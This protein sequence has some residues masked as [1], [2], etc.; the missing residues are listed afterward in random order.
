MFGEINAIR[1]LATKYSKPQLANLVQTGQLEPQKAVLAGMMIDRIAKSAMEPPQ[2]TVAQD[3]LGQAPTAGQMPPDQMQEGQPPQMPPQMAAG[4]GL[5]GMMPHSDGVTALHSGLN[6]MAG[7][8]IVA[9]ADGGDVPRFA[10]RGYVDPNLFKSVIAAESRGDPNA[11]SPK[12]ARGLAQLMPGT[13]RDPGYGVQG[14]R[15][16]SPEE[17]KRVG[18]DYLNALLK[19]YGN[20]DYALAAYNWGPGNTDK[21]IARGA[22]PEEL[23]AETRAYIPKVKAGMAQM[24]AKAPMPGGEQL[25]GIAD[26]IPS[27]QAAEPER[28]PAGPATLRAQVEKSSKAKTQEESD[29]E[30]IMGGVEKFGAA[31]KDVLSLPGRLAGKAVDTAITRPL[32]AFGVDVPYL[33]KEFYGGKEEFSI[34]PYMDAITKKENAAALPPIAAP[35]AKPA[36]GKP[37][38]TTV[39]PLA[40]K[41]EAAAA[42]EKAPMGPER[43]SFMD[44]VMGNLSPTEL[45]KPAQKTI[46]TVN[47]EQQ[48]ADKLY[49]VDTAKMF[50]DL[51]QDFRK[52]SGN[53]KDRSEKA[54]GMA[55]MM[56]GAGLMG[57]KKGRVGEALSRSGQQALGTYMGAMDKINDNEDKLQQRMQDLTMAENQF[58]RGRSDKALA[59]VQANKRDI[60]AIEIENVKLKN[61]AMIEGAKM[62]VDYFKNA[63]PPAYQYLQ[64]IVESEHARG[65]KSYTITDALH[66]EKTGGTKGEV[67]DKDLQKTYEDRLEKMINSAERKEF[68]RKYPTWR[69]F[70]A[71]EGRSGSKPS[72]SST[73]T[74][75][76]NNPL[77]AN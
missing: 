56:F 30:A 57:A 24:E 23:P 65:N 16:N 39:N 31:A 68:K 27:A 37:Q 44:R 58:N 19:K 29:R 18:N 34:S 15:D 8:G 75:D 43:P 7:G 36:A 4:G 5:M 67:T 33:P 77:L 76:R 9:F 2:T 60:Q 47:K 59:E 22:K 3:V 14:V 69:E 13:A 40:A 21:W 38:D 72:S 66:D 25:A 1:A 17:N 49:G 51:R 10:E 28:S 41:T 52:S 26:L 45:E 50:D 70:A 54:A 42:E 64:R 32:R 62:T 53:L 74:V 46:Q 61:Q 48:E 11:V 20:L 63:N 12:G 35:S 55:F 73:S 6:D 71:A